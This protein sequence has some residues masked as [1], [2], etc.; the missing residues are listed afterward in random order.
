MAL[1]IFLFNFMHMNIKKSKKN[2]SLSENF[3][4][5]LWAMTSPFFKYSPRPMFFFRRFLLRTFG[6]NVGKDVKIYGSAKIYLPWNLEIGNGS[7]IGEN[8]LIYNLGYVKI[9]SNTTISQRVHL[10][11]GTHDYRYLSMP[12]I[13]ERI[14][15][16]NN[17]WICA[18]SF[19]CPGVRVGDFAIVAAN[20]T[21]CKNISELD[22]VAGSPAKII[23]K[24]IILDD[25]TSDEF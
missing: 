20:S 11:A 13:R 8:A 24:R 1:G 7:S 12:L 23:K 17:C 21:V 9:G 5:V 4:R 16:G 22:I 18:D 2:Y 10:C 15:V 19:L 25:S 14:V 3:L 6:A